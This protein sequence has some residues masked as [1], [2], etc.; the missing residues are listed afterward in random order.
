MKEIWLPLPRNKKYAVS[1]RGRIKRIL[2][3]PGAVV[4]R[5]LKPWLCKRGYLQVD[6]GGTY[7]VVH[8]LV[9]ETFV[10]PCPKGT[11]KA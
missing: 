10:C 9:L 1:N 5:V 2:R 7:F 11:R 8:R 6:I 4:G 3:G